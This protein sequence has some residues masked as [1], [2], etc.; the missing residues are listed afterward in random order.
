M[1]ADMWD[2]PYNFKTEGVLLSIGTVS[3]ASEC[4]DCCAATSLSVGSFQSISQTLMIENSQSIND[5]PNCIE[6]GEKR[7]TLGLTDSPTDTNESQRS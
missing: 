7:E 5:I 1:F 4:I 3:L 6:R 2:L